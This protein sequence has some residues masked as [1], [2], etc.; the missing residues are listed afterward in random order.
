MAGLYVIASK[1][2]KGDLARIQYEA[3]F[4][5]GKRAHW[6]LLDR[7]GRAFLKGWSTGARFQRWHTYGEFRQWWVVAPDSYEDL[8]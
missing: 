7:N 1:D 2:I 8:L 5:E 3:W 6:I 4:S